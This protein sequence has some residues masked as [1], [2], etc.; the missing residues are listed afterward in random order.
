[1]VIQTKF[2]SMFFFG[3]SLLASG[4]DHTSYSG[5]ETKNPA[6]ESVPAISLP[7]SMKALN[8]VGHYEIRSPLCSDAETW[9]E[10]K[11]E[12]KDCLLIENSSDGWNIEL[13]SIQAAQNLCAFSIPMHQVGGVL[14]YSDGKDGEIILQE[15]D[16]SLVFSTHGID[17]GRAGFC[18]AHSGID[19]I[20]FPFSSKNSIHKK[21]FDE[22]EDE[23]NR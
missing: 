10:C 6:I 4:C 16:G 12:F 22:K 11:S 9:G 20:S 3:L 2:S 23:V 1:M 7:P 13:Y 21:Y 17:P 8:W 15:F 5:L 14:V 19:G 18:G